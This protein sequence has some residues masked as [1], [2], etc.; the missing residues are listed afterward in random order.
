MENEELIKITKRLDILI[1]ILLNKIDL[2]ESSVKDKDK[3][4][5]LNNLGLTITEIAEITGKSRQNIDVVLRRL[6]Q[7]K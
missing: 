5:L 7:G 4:E 2:S 3:I 6:K 1:N